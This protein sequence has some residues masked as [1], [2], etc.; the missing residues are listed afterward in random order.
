MT[1][2]VDLQRL[3]TR[4]PQCR[5]CFTFSK[6]ITRGRFMPVDVR[7][8]ATARVYIQITLVSVLA[9]QFTVLSQNAKLT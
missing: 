1:R 6:L 2:P 8:P 4:G 3:A 7:V 9:G 5:I